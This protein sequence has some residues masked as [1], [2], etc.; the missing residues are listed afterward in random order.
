M[1]AI[2]TRIERVM[3]I[4]PVGGWSFTVRKLTGAS[5]ADNHSTQADQMSDTLGRL[6]SDRVEA[7][8]C[9]IA[10]PG[11]EPLQIVEVFDP[12]SDA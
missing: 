12:N 2:T 11:L 10:G 6:I 7:K 5:F 3:I 8:I 9:T 1:V 4:N